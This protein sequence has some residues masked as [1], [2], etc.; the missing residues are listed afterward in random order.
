MNANELATLIS[1]L[2]MGMKKRLLKNMCNGQERELLIQNTTCMSM[3]D[4]R[5]GREI[6]LGLDLYVEQMKGH[7][8]ST[9]VVKLP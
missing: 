1:S 4:L 8:H 9:L 3:V 5:W 7:D 2:S 6:H